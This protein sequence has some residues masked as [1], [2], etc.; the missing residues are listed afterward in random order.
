MKIGGR[1]DVYPYHTNWGKA[2]DEMGIDR[3]LALSRIRELTDRAAESFAEAAAAPD[4]AALGRDLPSRLAD[5]V[6]Q[7]ATRCAQLIAPGSG[8]LGR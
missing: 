6:A 2:A 5:I 4:V 1:H 8:P 3:D 7:R